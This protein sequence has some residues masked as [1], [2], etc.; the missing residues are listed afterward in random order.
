MNLGSI[1]TISVGIILA[2]AVAMYYAQKNNQ[3]KK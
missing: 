1:V 2:I 3:N